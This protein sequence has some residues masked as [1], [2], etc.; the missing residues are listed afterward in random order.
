M[1]ADIKKKPLALIA[2][3]AISLGAFSAP[4]AVAQ[5]KPAATKAAKA[6]NLPEAGKEVPAGSNDG[7]LQDAWHYTC[8]AGPYGR[9]KVTSIFDSIFV[10]NGVFRYSIKGP[11]YSL[12]KVFNPE[13]KAYIETTVQAYSQQWAPAMAYPRLRPIGKGTMKALP[14]THY[15]G[16]AANQ[17]IVEGWFTDAVK[18]D[19]RLSDSLC[20]LCG[21]PAGYGLPVLVRFRTTSGSE[22]MFELLKLEKTKVTAKSLLVPKSY[23]LM[24]DQALFF[25][26]DEDGTNSGIDEFMISTPLKKKKSTSK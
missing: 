4:P 26:S 14:C 23:H 6:S 2:F 21:V 15:E 3:A 18:M 25:L 19:R 5:S 24:K 8:F 1:F 7:K 11:N 17:T 22:R 9:F 10:D 20:T 13:N 12:F 16:T